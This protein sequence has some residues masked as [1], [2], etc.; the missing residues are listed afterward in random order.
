MKNSQRLFP[1][2]PASACGA[3]AIGMLMSSS[4]SM[5]DESTTQR[6]I[7]NSREYVD[8]MGAFKKER[9]EQIEQFK[10]K[11]AE[12]LAALGGCESVLPKDRQPGIVSSTPPEYPEKAKRANQQGG[13]GICVRVLADGSTQ[14]MGI[15]QSSWF[16][17]L[18]EAA[19]SAVQSWKFS[20]AK[21]EQGNPIDDYRKVGV[22]FSLH[23]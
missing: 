20:V 13:V 12:M 18:D 11:D 22:N 4:V 16:P 2:V 23:D 19:L 6:I 17:S 5:S 3:L 15:I 1:C 21:D 9:E 10:K 8:A 7:K 14:L